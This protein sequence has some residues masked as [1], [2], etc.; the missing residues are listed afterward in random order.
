MLYKCFCVR[1]AAKHGVCLESSNYASNII[2]GYTI[3]TTNRNDFVTEKMKKS[4]N[5]FLYDEKMV[6]T[7]I[8]D[9]YI[10]NQILL[11]RFLSVLPSILSVLP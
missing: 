8:F 11:K 6:K 2:K 4:E 7:A 1:S 3:I 5:I 9:S 10:F